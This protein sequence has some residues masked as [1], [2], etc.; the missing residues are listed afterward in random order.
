MGCTVSGG[1][2]QG[3]GLL[4]RP[5]ILLSE[6]LLLMYKKLKY[7]SKGQL[8]Y[9]LLSKTNVYATLEFWGKSISIASFPRNFSGNRTTE[10]TTYFV[11]WITAFNV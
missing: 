10:E 8:E 2:S 11:V 1:I 5:H 9:E 7:I 4:K 3:A 6:L